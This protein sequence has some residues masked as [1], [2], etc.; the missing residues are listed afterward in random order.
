MPSKSDPDESGIS[1]PTGTFLNTPAECHAAGYG[2]AFGVAVMVPGLIRWGIVT[3]LVGTELL[4]LGL[5]VA[6]RTY[7]AGESHQH[8]RRFLHELRKERQYALL[9]FFGGVLIGG[10]AMLAPLPL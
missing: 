2:V 5:S 8:H 1:L 3:L 9:G 4:A 6:G 10:V 7:Y